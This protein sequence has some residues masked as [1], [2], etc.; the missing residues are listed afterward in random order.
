MFPQ[1]LVA[2]LHLGIQ[3]KLNQIKLKLNQA[4][5]NHTRTKIELS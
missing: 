4:E 3:N 5:L 1:N 2:T